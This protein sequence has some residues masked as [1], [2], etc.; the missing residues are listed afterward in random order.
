M[1]AE[2]MFSLENHVT[3]ML[4]FDLSI[5]TVT[6]THIWIPYVSRNTVIVFLSKIKCS[7]FA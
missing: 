2:V 6:S 5:E 3:K 1:F 7:K 4:K